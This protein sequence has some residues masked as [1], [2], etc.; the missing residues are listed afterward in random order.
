MEDDRLFWKA[1]GAGGTEDESFVAEAPFTFLYTGGVFKFYL[2]DGVQG[3]YT[4]NIYKVADA[5][6]TYGTTNA[7]TLNAT[8]HVLAYV[9]GDPVDSD[10]FLGMGYETLTIQNLLGID[11]FRSFSNWTITN[12]VTGNDSNGRRSSFRGEYG[13]DGYPSQGTTLQDTRSDER[14][15]IEEN[16]TISDDSELHVFSVFV[17]KVFDADGNQVITPEYDLLTTD[18]SKY[19]D[20]EL[21]LTGGTTEVADGDIMRGNIV[22]GGTRQTSSAEFTTRG[23]IDYSD[24]WRFELRVT[25]NGTGNTNARIRL[26]PAGGDVNSP[27]TVADTHRGWVIID[28]AQLEVSAVDGPS[29]PIVGGETLQPDALATSLANGYL[30]D[31]NFNDVGDV[32]S[33]VFA[34]DSDD[35]YRSILWSVSPLDSYTATSLHEM[36]PETVAVC[37]ETLDDETDVAID[38]QA[39]NDICAEEVYDGDAAVLIDAI[40]STPIWFDFSGADETAIDPIEG[41]NTLSNYRLT[42]QGTVTASNWSAAKRNSMLQSLTLDNASPGVGDKYQDVPGGTPDDVSDHIQGAGAVTIIFTIGTDI[43]SPTI[44]AGWHMRTSYNAQAFSSY[45]TAGSLILEIRGDQGSE[46]EAFANLTGDFTDGN[47]HVVA[48]RFNAGV[49]D[50]WFDDHAKQTGT[51]ATS[52]LV[53]SSGPELTFGDQGGWSTDDSDQMFTDL[54]VTWEAALTDVEI[55][56]ILAQIVA[57]IP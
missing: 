20:I 2:E 23:N 15:Y 7:N 9:T 40:S 11:K 29:G 12:L 52:T 42:N 16:I 10:I 38:D 3:T 34:F 33:G 28:W 46:I 8:T 48:L 17:R 36:G 41:H 1:Y 51:M 50:A 47:L 49:V 6:A 19:I 26:Y 35:I 18:P 27:N 45:F 53:K 32:T 4:L 56:A 21:A 44:M 31:E 54:F 25:N 55:E 57:E 22:T 37:V 13:I 24:W 5:L 30:Y 43:A 39:G 14:G